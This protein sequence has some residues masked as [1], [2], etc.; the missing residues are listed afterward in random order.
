MEGFENL[1]EEVSIL[2]FLRY[3]QPQFIIIA[4]L[5]FCLADTVLT[6]LGLSFNWIGEMNPIMN[7]VYYEQG[8]TWFYAIKMGLPCCLLLIRNISSLLHRFL[9]LTTALYFG[10]FCLHLAWISQ[11]YWPLAY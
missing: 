11:I 8:V 7:Y 4:L 1:Q 10:V 9:V 2:T 6:D 3:Y 5:F